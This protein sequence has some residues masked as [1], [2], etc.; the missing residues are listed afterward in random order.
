MI[1]GYQIFTLIV[2]LIAS[3]AIAWITKG[4]Y[5]LARKPRQSWKNLTTITCSVCEHP[6]EPEDMAW[7]PAYAAPICSLCCSLDSRCHDMC[8]PKARLN[9]QVATVANPDSSQATQRA[10]SFTLNRTFSAVT[11]RRLQGATGNRPS[12][13]CRAEG[14]E[15]GRAHV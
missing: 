1:Y 10:F 5:Y 15:I 14:Q 3:P 13:C 7:C 8:K 4:K 11:T 12:Q 6:F 9:T 2:A